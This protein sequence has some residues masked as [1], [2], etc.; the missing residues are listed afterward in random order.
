M[1]E[2]EHKGEELLR[3]NEEKYK[4]LVEGVQDYGIFML[5][6]EG[7][8]LSWNEGARK[9]KG[10]EEADIIG[11]H[12]SVFYTPEAKLSLYPQHELEEAI[13]LGRFEDEGMR[14]RKDGSLFYANVVITPLRSKDGELKGF[15]KITRDLTE[16]REAEEK[17]RLSEERYRL[18]VDGVR[19]YAIFLLSP[20]G[21]IES[22]NDGA[23]RLKGYE[24][25]EVI[26]KHFSIFYPQEAIETDFPQYEL[27]QAILLGKFQDEGYRIRKDGTQFYA[28]V[29]ITALFNSQRQLVGFSKVTRDLTERKLAEDKLTLNNQLLERRVKERTDELAKT[30]RELKLINADLDN[31]I[32]T[33]SH[34]LKAP[35]SN[36]EGLVS[37]LGDMLMD[38]EVLNEDMR[39]LLDMIQNSIGR[40]QNT[41]KD[42]ASVN[43]IQRAGR[44]EL[45]Q[46][47]MVEIV[48]DVMV[49]IDHLILESKAEIDLQ[50]GDEKNFK[51]SRI[52]MRSLVYNLV[53]NAIKYRSPKRK[54]KIE[55]RAF[56]EKDHFVLTIAD[57]GLGIKEENKQKIF[58]IFHRLHHHVDGTGIGLYIVKRITDNV[59]GRVEVT[60]EEEI[61]T[62]FKIYLPLDNGYSEISQN[63]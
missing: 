3:L 56:T 54:T 6:P 40:F 47:N 5:S 62:T 39:G 26:G 8:V 17:L 60:S 14:V 29:V 2:K 31:F 1:Q 59:G 12:F 38:K 63:Q 55:I 44:E 23:K 27:K 46:I 32:Y 41:I 20:E 28:N 19:D 22:W 50:L 45:T 15:S 25:E 11:N 10:Y 35:V 33:A 16:R 36:I 49:S 30:V 9:L 7:I 4:L 58:Q 42:L 18:L 24:K 52:H 37:A 34:D 48:K 43:E 61:G 13:R 57:N 51:F 21:F 53:I